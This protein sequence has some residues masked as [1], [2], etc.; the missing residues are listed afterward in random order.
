MV[1]ANV[2]PKLATAQFLVTRLTIQRRLK[3]SFD[4][5]II[6]P[7][8]TLTKYS[9]E[10]F[11]H[12]LLSLWGEMICKISSWL[13]FESIGLFPDTSTVDYKCPVTDCE[14][15]LFLIQIQLS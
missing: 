14:N 9:W 3:T 12:I 8:Q 5:Q 2:F 11:Y 13:K 6:K 1:V 7:F 15:L 10:H 4:S